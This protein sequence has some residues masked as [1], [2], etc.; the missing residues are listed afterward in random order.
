MARGFMDR[1]LIFMGIQEEPVEPTASEPAPERVQRARGGGDGDGSPGRAE[2][3]VAAAQESSPLPT[4]VAVLRPRVFDEVQLVA[5]ILKGGRPVVVSMEGCGRELAQRMV[6]FLSGATYALD[7][8]MRRLGEDIF[9]FTPSHM[10][11][12]EEDTEAPVEANE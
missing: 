11:I 6:D 10:S 3:E 2:D 1:V 4:Q 5:G 12:G 7:G 8:H 9:M